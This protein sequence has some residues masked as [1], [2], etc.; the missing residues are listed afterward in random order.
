MN[1]MNN[2]K[3]HH[4]KTES[5]KLH[6]AELPLDKTKL[7][8]IGIIIAILLVISI[9]ILIPNKKISENNK[10]YSI[11]FE[12]YGGSEIEKQNIKS[13]NKI[14]KPQDPT[15]EGY[16]FIGWTY[17][18]EVFDFSNEITSDIKLTAEWIEDKGEMYTI[19]FNSDG[20]T[21]IANQVLQKGDKVIKPSNPTKDNHIFIEW[22]YNG[23]TYNFDT[24]VDKNIEL[25]A[26]WQKV[27]VHQ[28]KPEE[29]VVKKYTV[30]F[31][32][33]GGTSVKSQTVI[34]GHKVTIPNSPTKKG[35]TF[36]GWTLNN[37]DYNFNSEVTKNIEL[38][39]KWNEIV[40][41]K[42]TVSFNSNGGTSI[43]SQYI[44]DGELVTKPTN[45]TRKG[46]TFINWQY[47]G[48]EYNFST[49]VTKNITLTAK[50]KKESYVVNFDSAG[51]TTIA[52]Q[53]IEYGN[54][55]TQPTNPTKEGYTFK[56]W[57]L[58]SKDYNFST[59]ITKNITL[60]ATWTKNK[61]TVTFDSTGGTAVSKQT[62]EYG[63]N[64]IQPTNPTKEGYTFYGWTLNGNAYNFSTPI[65]KNIVLVATWGSND[66]EFDLSTGTIIKYKGNATEVTIPESINGVKVTTLKANAFTNPNMTTLT[67]S[68]VINNVEDNAISKDSNTK[69]YTVY[70]SNN[71]YLARNDSWLKV[72]AMEGS[73]T[74]GKAP[75][76]AFITYRLTKGKCAACGGGSC[77]S[78]NLMHIK[79]IEGIDQI[80][81]STSKCNLTYSGVDH[82]LHTEH[83]NIPNI[84]PTGFTF[85]GWTGSNGLIPQKDVVIPAFSTGTKTY[86]ADCTE[87][88]WSFRLNYDN[89]QNYSGS[90][91]YSNVDYTQSPY[92][93]S[94]TKYCTYKYTQKVKV[95][96][97]QVKREG[98]K[99]K[100]WATTTWGVV[101][102]YEGQEISHKV[103]KNGGTLTLYARWEKVN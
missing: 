28:E 12:T 100:G 95:P 46:H 72:F 55:V 65:T 77:S 25:I 22:L 84:N 97:N 48:S 87:H 90:L 75:S 66:W 17:Q 93:G 101:E 83:F 85:N 99:F 42:Y 62:I 71:Q 33:N 27:E 60:V 96:Y 15:R 61:Y 44:S 36:A 74:G 49:K 69:L 76:G 26:K 41:N 6:Q 16:I 31:N 35:Y 56:S 98:Y 63:N 47:N 89:Y 68:S 1:K 34:H 13:G 21:T 14:K 91:D 32:S 20:G 50:W 92:C 24:N 10:T 11:S 58:N 70:M 78:S 5:R 9:V 51:G 82:Y 80:I 19:S 45:P 88:T 54:N 30:T 40:K 94:S 81:L 2:D 79:N 3:M 37:N 57:Q 18:G 4:R 38:V 8:I 23:T 73:C 39:A 86:T 67:F 52:Q 43:D 7:T 64:A 29:T 59:N 103:A 102:Y 53:T